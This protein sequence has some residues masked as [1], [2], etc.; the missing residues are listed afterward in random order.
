MQYKFNYI[1]TDNYELEYTNKN[2]EKI[3]KPFKR[4]VELAR[5]IQSIQAEGRSLMLE[6]MTKKGK[7]R[8]DYIIKRLHADG[9]ITYDESNLRANE[10]MFI[11]IATLEILKDI[12]K[13]LF[14]IT[15]EKLFLEMGLDMNSNNQEEQNKLLGFITKFCNI[16]SNGME[17]ETAPP[18]VENQ[19]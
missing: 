13:N 2:G 9:T 12:V 11:G 17:E 5:E 15:L 19:E 16:L 8:E 4:N 18:Y 3:K 14:N 6:S 7:T 10:E 1:S